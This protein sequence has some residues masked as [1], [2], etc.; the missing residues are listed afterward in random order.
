MLKEIKIG[1]RLY[2]S[3]PGVYHSTVVIKN[4][5][6]DEHKCLILNDGDIEINPRNFKLDDAVYI[7]DKIY[8]TI[9]N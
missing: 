8:L 3:V 6:I 4:K 9:S 5:K 7:S 1:S 2:I